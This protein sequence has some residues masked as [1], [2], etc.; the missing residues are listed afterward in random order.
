M[1]PFFTNPYPDELLYSA[2]AR[3]HFY[4][5]NL[6]CKDT[7]EELFGSRSVVPSVEIGSNFSIL[8]ER[9]G[10]QYSVESLL[11]NHTIYPYYA[12]FLSKQRQLEI[13]EDVKGEGQALYTRLGIVAGGICRKDGLYYCSICAKA[14]TERY[15]EPYIHREHQLQGIDYCPHHEVL[16]RKYPI[17]NDSR[18][19]YIRFELK[20]MDLSSTHKIDPHKEL[21]LHLAKQAYKLLHLPL[22]FLSREQINAKYQTLLRAHNL[23][24]ASNRVRQREMYQAIKS[25]LSGSFLQHYESTLNNND[26]YNWLRVLTRNSKRHVNPFRHLLFLYYL[27]QD[28]ENLVTI[29]E[30]DGAFGRGPFPCLNRAATHYKKFVIP[31]VVVTRDFKTKNSIG[32]F[33][34]SCGFVYS[35]K[36]TTNMFEIGRIKA[37]GD[38]W[39]EKLHD[40]QEQ[41]LS[42][43]AIARELGVDS[44]T[45]K[46]YLIGNVELK[47]VNSHRD[48]DDI[49]GIYKQNL[50]KGI[51]ELPNLSRTALRNKYKK[52]YMYLYRHDK[53]WLDEALPERR[54]GQNTIKKVNWAK[55]DQQYVQEIKRLHQKLLQSEKPIR[56]TISKIGKSLGILANLEQHL[57]KLPKTNKLLNDITE[58]LQDFQLRRCYKIID[59]LLGNDQGIFLWQVQRKAAIKSHHF[60]AIKPKLESYIEMKQEV[61]NN[62]RTTS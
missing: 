6:D 52:Q 59:D 49:L 8:A 31:N 54:Y 4:S 40:L 58:S 61:T 45:I 57:N 3:Y 1:L 36:H 27:Q 18:I 55:R 35:R 44:K 38:V 7:L 14:D 22:H 50:L 47:Q 16:L 28:V 32:T 29:N 25:I 39:L 56:I 60:H 2:I 24:T 10:P 62:E 34:C 33:T 21:A 23:I 53:A 26:E 46:R 11:A 37:F 5:G 13:L 48:N 42:I 41:N 51:K 43:R 9:L 19:E 30:D 12:L 15:G 17:T 20:H